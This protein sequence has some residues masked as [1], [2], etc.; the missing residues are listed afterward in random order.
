MRTRL[1]ALASLLTISSFLAACHEADPAGPA[2][3]ADPI[4]PSASTIVIPSVPDLCHEETVALLAGSDLEVGTVAVG[5]DEETLYV[6]YETAG[7]W[8]I[9]E[10]HLAVVDDPADIPSSGNAVPPGLFPGESVHQPPVTVV[11]Y[12]VPLPDPGG[13]SPVFVAAHAEVVKG[14]AEEGAWAEGPEIQEGGS[15][16]TYTT[17]EPA[18]CVEDDDEVVSEVIGSEGGTLET[19]GGDVTLDVPEGAL[20]EDV[21]L[22]IASVEAS[23]LPEGAV[24]G[25]AFD[26]GP[27]GQEFAEPVTLTVHYDQDSVD[28]DDEANLAIH[29][30]RDGV[31]ENV[32]STVNTVDDVITAEI[33]HFSVY[34]AVPSLASVEIR[35]DPQPA[36]EG[37]E[38]EHEVWV[39]NITSSTTLD[40]E[41]F[42]VEF[43]LTGDVDLHAYS[44]G[45]CDLTENESTFEFTCSVASSFPGEPGEAHIHRFTFIPSAGSEGTTL[46]ATAS[47][48]YGSQSASTGLSSTDVVGPLTDADVEVIIIE[49]SPLIATVGDPLTHL[50]D[51]VNDGPASVDGVTVTIEIV[52][53]VSVQSVPVDCVVTSATATG[54]LVTCALPEMPSRTGQQLEI[55]VVPQSVPGGEGALHT[56]ATIDDVQGATDPNPDN[57]SDEVFTPVEPSS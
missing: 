29:L 52:G 21:E 11:H 17:Y 27:D 38:I 48:T 28:D 7:G 45:L 47:F 40:P 9:A 32:P 37:E 13:A 51:V 25:T 36:P 39:R 44:T 10:T 33:T 19:D 14:G 57:D 22:S 24:E 18:A 30:L 16:A 15:W 31:W 35:V 54:V 26:F 46:E 56:I 23:E 3:T 55:T 42:T 6:T 53:E 20:E 41:N 50:V 12:A 5:N 2:S 1:A 8:E 43:S 34:G 49:T 4:G